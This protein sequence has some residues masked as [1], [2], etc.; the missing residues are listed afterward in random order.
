MDKMFVN[1]DRLAL[2]EFGRVRLDSDTTDFVLR[3]RH[4]VQFSGKSNSA[5]CTGSNTNCTNSGD[6]T[7]TSNLGCTNNGKCNKQDPSPGG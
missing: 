1:V 4:E 6:C 2:D 7:S 3:H 5:T